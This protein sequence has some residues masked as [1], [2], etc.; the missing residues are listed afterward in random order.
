MT[1]SLALVVS[2]G[3]AA[4]AGSGASA[5]SPETPALP[6]VAIRPEDARLAAAASDL[7][8]RVGHDLNYEVDAEVLKDH[9][10]NLQ[11]ELA[12]AFESIARGLEKA[13]E[14][15]PE[16]VAKTTAVVRTIRVEL[17]EKTRDFRARVAGDVLYLY[18]PT[19]TPGF[20][21]DAAVRAALTAN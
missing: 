13:R 12:E 18:V 19:H 7:Q 9:A 1:R 3:L 20:T 2:L 16:G 4:C 14:E 5:P 17:D 21:T 8:A 11:D 10:P 15:N 6:Y